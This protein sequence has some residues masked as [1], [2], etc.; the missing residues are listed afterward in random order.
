[1]FLC[2]HVYVF[3]VCVII[4]H[5]YCLVVLRVLVLV[6]VQREALAHAALHLGRISYGQF[7]NVMLVFAA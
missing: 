4:V 1:M 2:Y 3:S 6:G 7:Q 5:A